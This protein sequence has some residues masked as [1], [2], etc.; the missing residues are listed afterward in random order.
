MIA[1]FAAID[2]HF[3]AAREGGEPP[4]VVVVRHA[5]ARRVRTWVR[6]WYRCRRSRRY[7]SI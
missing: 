1:A 3:I 7:V 5:P 6:R 2:A 4:V